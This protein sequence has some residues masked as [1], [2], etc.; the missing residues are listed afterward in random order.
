MVVKPVAKLSEKARW[1]PSRTRLHP[2][3]DPTI[4]T[5]SKGSAPGSPKPNKKAGWAA[6]IWFSPNDATM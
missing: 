3:P 4:G 6:P 5:V 1:G 2:L